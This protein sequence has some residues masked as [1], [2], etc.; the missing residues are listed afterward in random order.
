MA[1][2]FPLELKASGSDWLLRL[3]RCS[4]RSWED[5]CEQFFNVF[6]SG[7]KHPGTLNDLL[8]LSQHPRETLHNFMENF[9]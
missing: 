7:Y 1:N 3:P 8:A 2:W 4:M 6:Q 9:C 5:L